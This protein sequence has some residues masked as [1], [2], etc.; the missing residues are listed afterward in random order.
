[1]PAKSPGTRGGSPGVFALADSRL[2]LCPDALFALH[3][4]TEGASGD[5]ERAVP[6]SYR[7]GHGN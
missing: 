2:D 1:M 6:K 4:R 7:F 3:N 5:R